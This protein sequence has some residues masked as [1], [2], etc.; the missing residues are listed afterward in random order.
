MF[1]TLS[2]PRWL[3]NLAILIGG[4]IGFLGT[5]YFQFNTAG[6]FIFTVL[7]ASGAVFIAN[8]A[9]MVQKRRKQS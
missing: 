5:Q 6:S 4:G 7:T 2:A 3:V 9:W 8:I 1:D